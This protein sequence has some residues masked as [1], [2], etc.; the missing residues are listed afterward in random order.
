MESG[1][2]WKTPKMCFKTWSVLSI[3]TPLEEGQT[4]NSN[5]NPNWAQLG[6]FSLSSGNNNQ[7]GAKKAWQ[8]EKEE[9]LLFCYSLN[10]FF[11]RTRPLG[12]V[13][14]FRPP[15]DDR[16]RKVGHLKHTADDPRFSDVNNRTVV[17]VRDIVFLANR[18]KYVWK[19]K[20][21]HCVRV[22]TT[23]INWR[24]RNR[25]ACKNYWQ[26]FCDGSLKC[27]ET[28]RVRKKRK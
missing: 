10:L 1:N 9:E 27:K 5:L 24:R 19:A 6:S 13:T 16:G 12:W 23:F 22:Q 21:S 17:T 4:N 20:L 3:L 15:R 18:Y 8:V 11:R 2:C 25:R 28:W 26:D 7:K 14:F